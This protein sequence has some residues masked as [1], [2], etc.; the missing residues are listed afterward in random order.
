[1]SYIS[2]A[3]SASWLCPCR[4]KLTCL[5]TTVTLCNKTSLTKHKHENL[6]VLL[7]TK[8]TGPWGRRNRI[9]RGQRQTWPL[10]RNNPDHILRH[11]SEQKS[12]VQGSTNRRRKR[13]SASI[14]ISPQSASQAVRARKPHIEHHW[15]GLSVVSQVV[16][17]H[18]CYHNLPVC[19][20]M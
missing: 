10:I 4:C 3:N 5:N 11:P 17:S 8:H 1:M 20:F 2:F 19:A 13:I 7:T 6:Q 9:N 16:C 14:R 15:W 12:I 18:I